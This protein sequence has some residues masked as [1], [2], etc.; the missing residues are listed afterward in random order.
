MEIGSNLKKLRTSKG[1]T[2]KDLADSLNVSYQAVSRWENDEVEPDISTLSKLSSIFGVSV[3]AIIN[4]KNVETKEQKQSIDEAVTIATTVAV[5][6]QNKQS[7][8][9][10]TQTKQEPVNEEVGKCYA[11]GKTLYKKDTYNV[12]R[13]KAH[14]V[15]RRGH[16]HNVPASTKYYC[17]ECDVLR[18]KGKLSSNGTKLPKY[19]KKRLVFGIIFGI[20]TLVISMILLLTK[21]NIN[22]AAAVFLPVLFGYGVFAEI[23]CLFTDCYIGEVFLE[24]ATWSIKLPGII[25]TF[26][27]DGLIFLIVMK[28]LFAIL[29]VFIGIGVFLLAIAISTTL[30]IFTFPFV[31]GKEGY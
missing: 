22:K 11:C 18:A 1:M 9:E 21:T 19:G 8:Q 4:G 26:D 15:H 28:I 31:I 30:S 12:I 2:Q 20:V 16:H 6:S 5:A 29:G 24:I 14:T 7:V 10:V 27:L 13:T 25:F 17:A 23:Y 3:D